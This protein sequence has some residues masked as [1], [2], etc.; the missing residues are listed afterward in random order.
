MCA[1]VCDVSFTGFLSQGI[2]IFLEL[3]LH[4]RRVRGGEAEV[5][6]E[7]DRKRQSGRG[8]ERENFIQHYRQDCVCERGTIAKTL[9]VSALV[10][11]GDM[12][13]Y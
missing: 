13:P 4:L 9:C 8:K 5:E 3:A 7:G 6:R 12:P 11:I 10:L 2:L 1:C